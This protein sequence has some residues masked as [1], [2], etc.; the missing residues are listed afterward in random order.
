MLGPAQVQSRLLV[1]RQ[2]QLPPPNPHRE[3]RGIGD[4]LAE[5]YKSGQSA[6]MPQDIPLDSDFL[7]QEVLEIC[8]HWLQD[9][10]NPNIHVRQKPWFFGNILLALIVES[11]SP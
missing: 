2:Q 8:F 9:R 3:L 10:Q 5:G 4:S 11:N 1:Y 7:E 6:P